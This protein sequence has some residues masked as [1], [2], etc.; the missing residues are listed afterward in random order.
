M[1]ILLSTFDITDARSL[2]EES[3]GIDSLLGSSSPFFLIIEQEYLATPGLIY[4]ARYEP[5]ASSS[6]N[7]LNTRP[8]SAGRG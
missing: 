4:L 7:L 1:L 6:L 3:P 8:L 2:A 5:R